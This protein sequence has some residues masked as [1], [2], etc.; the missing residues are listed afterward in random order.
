MPITSI[1]QVTDAGTLHDYLL[2]VQ[3]QLRSGKMRGL[4]A[5]R[6]VAE[7]RKRLAELKTGDRNQSGSQS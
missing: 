6:R 2:W 3:N 5:K 4:D 1:E 7:A